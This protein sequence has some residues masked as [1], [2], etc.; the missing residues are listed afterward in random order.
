MRIAMLSWESLNTIAVGGVAAHVSELADA[1]AEKGH[2][3][4]IFTRAGENQPEYERIGNVHEHRCRYQYCDNL[5]DDVNKMCGAI[6]EQVIATEDHIGPFDV[7]HAHDWLAANAMIWLKQ[8]RGR[9]SILTIHSTEYGRCGNTFPDGQS[10]RVREQ[11]RA[12]LYWCDH[13]IAVSGVTQAELAGMY[14]VPIWKTSVVHNGVRNARFEVTCDPA[15]EKERYGIDRMDPT[16]LFC[17]RM[18]YQKGP[19]LLLE[20]IPSIL[21]YYDNA[22]F[23]FAGDGDMRWSLEERARDMGIEHAVRFLGYRNGNELPR[24]FKLAD[25]VCVPSRNEPF[26]IV[27]LEAWSAGKPVVV[28]QIGGPAEYVAHEQTGLKVYPTVDSIAWG[29]GTMFMDF[30]RARRM[31][32]AGLETV[33]QRFTWD[34]IAEKTLAVYDPSHVPQTRDAMQVTEAIHVNGRRSASTQRKHR[35]DSSAMSTTN[36]TRSTSRIDARPELNP[37][38]DLVATLQRCRSMLHQVE[39]ILPAPVENRTY[40]KTTESTDSRAGRQNGRNK[41][42]RDGT[43]RELASHMKH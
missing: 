19:D 23:I 35:A 14:D 32:K 4:H 34:R 42:R 38:E 33:Q 41:T 27:V 29:L 17:G 24:L 12:G 28:T 31:G 10:A 20:A 9:R 37:A 18:A 1:L 7:I 8:Q 30:D 36:G 15:E 40:R 6:V 21:K 2:E 43:R 11:E 26:G 13:V 5:V 22:K 3:V 16:V 39:S 25:M